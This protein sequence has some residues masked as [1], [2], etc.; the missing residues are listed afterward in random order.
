M[1]AQSDH[2]V[3]RRNNKGAESS[4]TPDSVELSAREK[5]FRPDSDEYTRL[6]LKL[7]EIDL[8]AEINRHFR[9]GDSAYV[10]CELVRGHKPNA[11]RTF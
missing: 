2:R 7:G 9:G 11:E 6:S 3:N 10:S 8:S 4:I 5:S 1:I